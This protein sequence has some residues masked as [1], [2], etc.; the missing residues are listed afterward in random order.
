[1]HENNQPPFFYGATATVPLDGASAVSLAISYSP[2][3]ISEADLRCH[4]HIFLLEKKM[5]RSTPISTECGE[6]VLDPDTM[7]ELIFL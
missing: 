2:W 4:L 7:E 1:M 5:P 6:N 3:S